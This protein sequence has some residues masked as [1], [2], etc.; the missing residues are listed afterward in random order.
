MKYEINDTCILKVYNDANETLAECSIPT[1]EAKKIVQNIING[2]NKDKTSKLTNKEV[3]LLSNIMLNK[4]KKQTK[5][6][7]GITPKNIY[8]L[9]RIQDICRALQEYSYY[10]TS[11]NN[12]ESMIKWSEVLNERLGRLKY[13]LEDLKI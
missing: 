11:I 13:D 7:L 5:P 12:Y 4:L 3:E 1:N 6:P 9:Q 2:N 8:E 10:E